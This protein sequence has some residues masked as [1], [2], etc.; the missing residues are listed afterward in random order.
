VAPGLVDRV[1]GEL[2]LRTHGARIHR[3]SVDR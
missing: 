1:E 3:F 2:A